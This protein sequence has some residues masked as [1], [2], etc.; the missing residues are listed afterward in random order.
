MNSHKKWAKTDLQVVVIPGFV[1]IG[2]GSRALPHVQWRVLKD[3]TTRVFALGTME[4]YQQIMYGEE[5]S[6]RN[7]SLKLIYVIYF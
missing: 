5:S 2:V 6:M 3:D 1:S 7:Y 4:I